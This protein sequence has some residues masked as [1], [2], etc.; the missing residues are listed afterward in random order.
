MNL[1]YINLWLSPDSGYDDDYRYEFKLHTRFINHFL[2]IQI[3][4]NKY[5][6]DGSFNMISITPKPNKIEESRIVP[7][8]VLR[9]EVPFNKNRYDQIKSTEDCSYYLELFEEGFKNASKFKQIP[10]EELLNLV[11]EFKGN[12]CKNEWMHKKKNFK[13][14]DIEVKLECYFTTLDFRLVATIN[15]ISTKKQLCSGTVIRTLPDE[16]LFDKMFKDILIHKNF[17]IVTD[18]SDSARVL[19]NLEDAKKGIFNKMFA[20]YIYDE[21]CTQEE[22]KEFEDTHNDVVKMLSYSGNGF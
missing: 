4:K 13:E 5:T 6:T 7:L 22:N 14:Q 8:E 10:L 21:D 1:R 20:P 16:N 15:Q 12:G 2:S 9:V 3:R 19:I 18:A 17:I 11:K